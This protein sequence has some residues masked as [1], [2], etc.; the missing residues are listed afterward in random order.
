MMGKELKVLSVNLHLFPAWLKQNKL[1]TEDGVDGIV[2][3]IKGLIGGDLEPDI[4]VFQELWAPKGRY[5]MTKGLQD[6]WPYFLL[7]D[8][9]GRFII[10]INS[11]LAIF[12]KY[13]IVDY[14]RSDYRDK[15]G[16]ETFARKG[17]LGVKIEVEAKYFYLFNTHLQSGIGVIA[18]YFNKI[19]KLGHWLSKII[20]G[21]T[22]SSTEV[23]RKQ[24]AQAEEVIEEFT[25]GVKEGEKMLFCGD[26]NT[27]N[28][29]VAEYDNILEVLGAVDT[30]DAELSPFRGTITSRK[31]KDRRIDFQFDL[32]RGLKG[33][34]IITE[35]LPPPYS[36]HMTLHGKFEC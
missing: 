31:N 24:V 13:P 6:I 10:G 32:S 35:T 9:C 30:F 16:D 33:Y 19:P 12:S 26:F 28:K 18:E 25:F 34:S 21:S 14:I 20:L 36:D 8:R 15:M 3:R 17:C 4:L 7:D 1:S 29:K 23:R 5:L 27:S 22:K 2:E 11:G